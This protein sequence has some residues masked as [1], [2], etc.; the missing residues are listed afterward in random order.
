MAE[1]LASQDRMLRRRGKLKEGAD[2]AV[3]VAAFEK[4]LRVALWQP[5]GC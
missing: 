2:P 5:Q 4:Y 1:V 3:M